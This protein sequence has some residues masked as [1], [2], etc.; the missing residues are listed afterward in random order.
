MSE[1]N[2]R[3]AL[4][5]GIVG[6]G[7]AG[8]SMVPALQKHPNVRLTAVSTRNEERGRKFAEDFPV[9]VYPGIEELCESESVDA[10]YV[11]TPTQLHGE[12]AI[13][14]AERGKHV[15]VEK[16]IAVTLE[17]AGAMIE[18]AERN[19]VKMVVGPSQSFEPPIRKIRE[20]VEGGSL[21]RVRMIHNWYFNDW[22]YRPRTP[23]E[24]DTGQG[25]GVTYRQGAHQFDIIRLIGGGMVRSVRAMTGRWDDDRPTE[26]A[27]S[28]FLEFED[29]TAA[30]AVYNGYDR[31]HTTE[32]TF[33][34]GE[35]GPLVTSDV[36]G[37]SRK[38]IR[39]S[40]GSDAEVALKDAAG[41][42]GERA[43]N[44]AK[45]E[46]H[47]PFFGLTVVSCERGDIRQSPDG[48]L[49]YGPEEKEEVILPKDVTGRDALIGELY[50]AVA[51]DEAPLHDGRWGRANIEVCVAALESA[52][53]RKEVY[54]SHQTPVPE[55]GNA[56]PQAR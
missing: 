42:G 4:R 56:L 32:I 48:L 23:D 36:Y 55:K 52:R 30:T 39:K 41:Y 34:I 29:R 37:R 28:V 26:G 33:G 45:T 5:V 17:E 11:A 22:M 27:H 51:N 43:K 31:F 47:H 40:G 10:V 38:L 8:S 9:E 7:I 50:E 16:P 49:V 2:G 35:G 25:G 14:A 21:G 24:L 3:P 19:G 54:L 13:I 12:H 44:Y 18:A 1:G 46:P 20:I 15:I 53:E 6:L